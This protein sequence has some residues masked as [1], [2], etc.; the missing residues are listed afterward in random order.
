MLSQVAMHA[1]VRVEPLNP[2]DMQSSIFH[3]H[4]HHIANASSPRAKQGTAAQADVRGEARGREAG[5][6]EGQQK[7]KLEIARNLK[8]AGLT[9]AQI[10]TATGLMDTD[11]E[12]I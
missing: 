6:L 1:I 9:N 10:K 2:Y 8:A 4:K 3:Q 7:A 12:Q 11:L 5:R